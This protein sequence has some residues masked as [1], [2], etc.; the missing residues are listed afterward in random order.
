MTKASLAHSFSN[1]AFWKLWLQYTTMILLGFTV[2]LSA[3]IF[4]SPVMMI[5]LIIIPLIIKA[6]IYGSVITVSHIICR[7]IWRKYHS[8]LIAGVLIAGVIMIGVIWSLPDATHQTDRDEVLGHI[9]LSIITIVLCVLV[10]VS[11]WI[12]LKMFRKRAL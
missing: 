5:P 10:L 11:R 4:T 9:G 8:K 7:T 3:I 6:V 2:L 12:F 1:Q